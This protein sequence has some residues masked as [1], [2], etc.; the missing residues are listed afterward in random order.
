MPRYSIIK[1]QKIKGK[2][3][4]WIQPKVGENVIFIRQKQLKWLNFSWE[5]MDTKRKQNG[6][7]NVEEKNYPFRIWD[8]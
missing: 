8:T 2:E 4:S 6:I 7:L 5:T 1:L 3:V